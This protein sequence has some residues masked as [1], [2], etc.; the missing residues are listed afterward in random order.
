MYVALVHTLPTDIDAI[1][2]AAHTVRSVVC[3]TGS[4]THRKTLQMIGVHQ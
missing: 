3:P 1:V 2:P 4:T